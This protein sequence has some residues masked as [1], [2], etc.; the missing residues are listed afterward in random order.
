MEG[1]TVSN[2]QPVT[3]PHHPHARKAPRAPRAPTSFN[4]PQLPPP[5]QSTR[6]VYAG[7]H[8]SNAL[9]HIRKNNLSWQL[10][11]TLR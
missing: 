11:F 10:F 2:S 3:C 8:R 7:E 4:P 6:H 5:Q 9:Q 1:F